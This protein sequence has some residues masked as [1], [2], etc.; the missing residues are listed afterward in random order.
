MI[1]LEIFNSGSLQEQFASQSA[2]YLF[3]AAW[4]D[5]EWG[6]D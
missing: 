4:I 6:G 3:Q 5:I 2:R 1:D